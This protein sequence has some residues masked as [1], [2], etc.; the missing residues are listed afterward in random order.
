MK[1]AAGKLGERAVAAKLI[2]SHLPPS[3]NLIQGGAETNV[4]PEI[5]SRMIPN[6]LGGL[7]I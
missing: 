4:L 2:P 5:W 6:T 3:K 7:I 1:E